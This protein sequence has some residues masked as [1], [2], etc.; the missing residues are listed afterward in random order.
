VQKSQNEPKE[1]P[2]VGARH[3][4]PLRPAS[5]FAGVAKATDRQSEILAEVMKHSSKFTER[6]L[7]VYEN[8]GSLLKTQE[9]SW[10]IIGNKGCYAF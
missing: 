6:S 4:V 2:I 1:S 7:N 5:A 3:G 10:N 9:P 8:K